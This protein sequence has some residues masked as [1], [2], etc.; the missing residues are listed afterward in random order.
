MKQRSV[1]VVT[2]SRAD[3]S[4][5]YW[6]LKQIQEDSSL[7]PLIIVTGT[8]LSSEHGLTYKLLEKDGFLINAKLKILRY[9]NNEVGVTKAIG[10][11]CKLF[12]ETF[13]R[14]QPDIVVIFADRFEMFAAA[15]AAYTAKI[16]IA[17]IH[18]GETSQG[19]VDEAFRHSITKMS[20]IHFAAT[21]VYRKRIIQLGENPNRVFNYGSPSLEALNYQKLL[22]REEL[23]KLLGFDFNGRVALITYHPVTLENDLP[24]HQVDAVLRAV[25]VFNLK[26]IFTKSNA[27]AHGEIINRQVGRFCSQ[28]PERY[29]LFDALGPLRYFS[30][31]KYCNLMIGNSSSG[32]VEAPS[33]KLPVVNIGDRQKGRLRSENIISVGYAQTEIEKGIRRALSSRFK[34]TLNSMKNPYQRFSDGR[35]SYRIKEK[36]KELEIDNRLFKKEFC[37]I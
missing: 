23:E 13:K 21:E 7:R 9:A 32:F 8:H 31:L 10:E 2:S 37:D 1:C 20:S 22:N 26:A 30:V 24:Q 25:D 29:R 12:A 15:I 5:L 35:A 19:A 3:Y 17:H 28:H 16:P 18:G 14:L 6:L 11:G 27:D 33:F 36:L 34:R 4:H